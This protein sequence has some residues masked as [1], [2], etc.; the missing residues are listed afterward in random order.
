MHRQL[1][2]AT[3]R[4]A[5]DRCDYRFRVIGDVLPEPFCLAVEHF[6][7][8]PVRHVLQVRT[9]GE[10]FLVA[11]QHH[12]Q[13]VIV[14]GQLP[15]HPGQLLTDFQIERVQCV[16]AVDADNGNVIVFLAVARMIENDDGHG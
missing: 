12:G 5:V 9:S 16:R 2:P 4:V 1:Q 8:C 7:R 10:G 14:I 6:D 11:G 3:E 13:H 15:E